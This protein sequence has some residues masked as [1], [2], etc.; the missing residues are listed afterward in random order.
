MAWVLQ[1]RNMVFNQTGQMRLV[2]IIFFLIVT[3]A[4]DCSKIR[5]VKLASTL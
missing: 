1:N 3:H 2:F 5:Y 4:V